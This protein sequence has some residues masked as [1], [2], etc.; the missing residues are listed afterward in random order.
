MPMRIAVFIDYQ[1][2]Y[3]AARDAFHRPG[4]HAR[5]GH[6]HP[7]DMAE[8][9]AAKG[10][11][12]YDLTFVGVY[13]G[14]ADRR[15]DPRTSAARARQVAAWRRHGGVTAV[16][17]PLRY[18][19]GWPREKAQEKGIDVKIAIDALMLAV[20]RK[21][22]IAVIASCDSD[23][24]PLAEALF[25]LQR[26]TG[27]PGVEAIAWNGR[28]GRIGLRGKQM[29]YREVDERDYLAM[30]DITDY[31]SAAGQAPAAV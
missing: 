4:A 13:C 9:L 30:Q 12:D 20:Q 8:L 21:Y 23:L 31:D 18:P 26:L 3:G 24:A 27:A 15:R 5:Y 17:R 16:T 28:G 25:E 1:N 11:P 29:A 22:D 7:R 14:I 2:C 6:F 10:G 19:R